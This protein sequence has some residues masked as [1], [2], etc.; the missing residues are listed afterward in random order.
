MIENSLRKV[1][2]PKEV[3]PKNINSDL[4]I[5]KRIIVLLNK[6]NL[7]KFTQIN[8]YNFYTSDNYL[9]KQVKECKRIIFQTGKTIVEFFYFILESLLFTNLNCNILLD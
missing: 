3:L 7:E 1:L 5:D 8:S 9:F 6:K 4:L 2:T